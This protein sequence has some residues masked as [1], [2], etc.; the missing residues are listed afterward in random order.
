[1]GAILQKMKADLIHRPVESALIAVTVTAA[2]ALL[3]LALATLMNLSA[4]YDRSFED[5]NGAHLWLYFNREQTRRRDI[6]RIEALPGVAESTGLQVSLLCRA[7]V[8][9]T[10]VWGSLRALPEQP[11]I[12]NRL[13]LREGRYPAPH[14]A[15]VL[16]G[17]ELHDAY[18][19][20]VGD[21]VTVTTQGG[22]RMALRVVGLAYN[23]MWDTYR[24][25]QPPY[26]YANREI[27]RRLAPDESAW[28]WSLGLRLTDPQA[29]EETVAQVEASLHRDAL[30]G[31]TDW[32]D[33]RQSAIFG[34]QL[35][36]VFLGAFS[37]F[38]ILATVL[39]VTTSIGSAVLNQ[40]RQI[41]ILKAVGF[42]GGQVLALYTGQYLAL[43][44]VACPVGLLLG[45]WFSPLPLQSAA[46]S[47]GTTFR[48]PL[49]PLLIILTCVTIL[50]VI[51][52]AT[53]GA[54]RRGAR[55]NII[56]AISTGAEAPQRR[57]PW[58]VRWAIRLRLPM[59]VVLGLNN[60]FARPFRS[61]LTGLNLTLGVMGIL[62]GLALHETLGVYRADPSLLGI[63]YDAVVTRGV[64]SHLEV[65]H[66]LRRAPGVIGFY[67]E[68]RLE[69][70]TPDGRLFQVRAVEGDLTSFPLRL[71]A[72]RLFQPDSREAIAGQGLL[73]WLGLA[74]GDELTI[75]MGGEEEHPVTLRI[76]GQYL[77]PVNAGEMLMASL[78][79]LA[80]EAGTGDPQTYYLALDSTADPARLETYLE[81]RADVDLTVV[82]Q[83]VPDAVFYLQLAIFALAAIL[84]G[85]ALVNVFNTTL[86]A[87]QEQKRMVGIL[88]TV[89][90]TPTQVM[91]MV[92]NTAGSLGLMATAL[93]I[94]LGL[95]FTRGLLAM[96]ARIYGFGEVHVT[97]NPLFML[98]LAP[99]MVL[100]SVAGSLVPARQAARSPIVE[101]LRRE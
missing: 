101:V 3:T 23:P 83:A 76:V 69:V 98:L 95:A 63:P 84:I 79:A 47:L 26:L 71:G 6:E 41:G 55:T 91:A 57:S 43:G 99:L 75:I 97:V 80:R 67:A 59:T 13:W 88:K 20:A 85:I 77:E 27:L 40:F 7:D 89:G 96:L 39:V 87:M 86:L 8:G 52:S 51:G 38:A 36:M 24:S 2:T 35:N 50:G 82:G 90:M 30:T 15:E 62:F 53:L 100:V 73:D 22:R 10:R 37:L 14:Q 29:V 32:R 48:P 72:G 92:G 93:G 58:A 1:M 18:R 54:A 45:A 4:P 56:R 78:P 70:K 12:V 81:S 34:V 31:H 60:L 42:T 46:A 64:S 68:R 74:V 49:H 9:G 17:V 61:L 19:L 11:P 16:A 65:Q 5:L 28:D 25:S 44:L 33:V 66:L 21:T 94:P